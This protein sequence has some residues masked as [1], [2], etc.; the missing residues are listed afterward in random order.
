MNHEHE[1]HLYYF[2]RYL[3]GEMPEG[4]KLAFEEKLSDDQEFKE[5]FEYHK[6]NRK[7]I[8]LE[9]LDDYEES[10]ITTPQR[11]LRWF[12][13]TISIVGLV[14]IID[15][16]FSTSYDTQ[17]LQSSSK[18][19]I[20]ESIKELSKSSKT[21]KDSF[22]KPANLKDK[23][24][25]KM[26]I[27]DKSRSKIIEELVES[28]TSE[29]IEQVEGALADA[30]VYNKHSNGLETDVF[31]SD[32]LVPV[33]EST[34]F[35]DRFRAILMET[36]SVLSDS[37]LTILTIKSLQRH[38]KTN[39]KFIFVEL[40]RSP[41]KFEGYRFSGKKLL[42]YGFKDIHVSYFINEKNALWF[43]LVGKKVEL[44]PDNKYHKFNFLSTE[45]YY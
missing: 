35:D 29:I 41:I 6:L 45:T 14:L 13:L 1:K 37:T 44:L 36:D 18:S 31:I 3:R 21:K 27:S 5:H 25:E 7:E 43:C 40:W 20:I 32:T 39:N 17:T 8:L 11:G 19:R 12:Y 26:S 22:V 42:I 16:Y 10:A 28:D 15:Y 23:T 38:Q 2:E 34:I 9:E 4:E 24:F 30:I 33:T